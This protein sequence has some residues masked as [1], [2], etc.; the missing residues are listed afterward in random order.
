MDVDFFSWLG[1]A[2]RWFHVMLAIMWIGASFYFVWLDLSLRPAKSKADRDKGVSGEVWAVHGGGFYHKQ[3]YMVAPSHMPE[4]LHWFKWESY[5]TFISGFLLLCLVYY[6]NAD[7]YLIDKAKMVLT[8]LQ[9][10]LT[11]VMFLIGG[12]FFYDTLCKSPLG[13]N[14]K[15]FSV[16][17]AG[18]LVAA[19][20]ALC[21]IFT[22]RGAFIHVGAMIGTA[23]TAN[24]F[25]IIIPNQKKV[26]KALLAGDKPDAKYGKIAKQRSMHNNYMTLPVLLIMLS[27]HYPVLYSGSYNW[28]ILSGL[29]LASWPFRHFFNLKDRGITNYWYAAAGIAGYIFVMLAAS[30]LFTPEKPVEVAQ[31]VSAA[32]VRQIV[33]THC[34]ACHSDTPVHAGI[35][36]APKGVMF[37]TMDEIKQNAPRIIE[38]AVKNDTMPLGNETGMTDDDRKKLGA[39]LE[40]LEKSGK[41][42]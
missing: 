13:D 2:L 38:Q 1:L 16:L 25:A 40:A 20:Y 19:C 7:L 22:G 34:S 32:E 24:V 27:N 42:P 30:G 5:L 33:R 3:K 6:F 9:A 14:V 8:P 26:V 18:A 10:T 21:Q 39:G 12:W 37:D 23:M 29:G 17:W 11:G 4:E 36:I 41:Q 15:V 31:A 28:A 35:A